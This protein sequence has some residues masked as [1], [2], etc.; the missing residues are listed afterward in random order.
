MRRNVEAGLL[1]LAVLAGFYQ[2]FHLAGTGFG[3]GFEM[4][5]IAKSLVDH[6]TYGNPFEPAIT[7]PTALVP[8]LYPL[9]LAALLK[10]FGSLL[11]MALVADSVNIFANAL[12]AALMP[13]LSEVFFEDWR[14][15]AFAGLL[16]ICSMR[17]MPQWDASCTIA[18]LVVFCLVTARTIGH[19]RTPAWQAAAAGLLAGMLSL[20]NPATAIVFLSWTA[21]LLFQRRAGLKGAARYAAVLLL[22]LSAC[23]APWVVRNYR[24]WHA[25]VLRTS[26]GITLYSSNNSCAESSLVKDA[27][28]GC[29]QATHPVAS[30]AEAGLLARLGEV[31]YDRDRAAAAW[32]W[33]RGNPARFRQLTLARI[34][35]FWFPEP[36]VPPYPAYGIWAITLLSIPGMALMARQRHA[37][38]LF[39]LAVWLVY[40][41]M[42]YLV[43]SCDRYRYPILW[44]SMLPAGYCLAALAKRKRLQ[45]PLLYSEHRALADQRL[46]AEP[47]RAGRRQLSA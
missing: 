25:F 35:E 32:A 13:R 27:A 42:Y 19:V 28:H 14:P 5:A 30:L 2:F 7:G 6:G 34:I 23:N 31:Q 24:I 16:W 39:V 44:T 17:L 37:V 47:G 43:V 1:C 22:V 18:G 41:L 36:I 12:I 21:F 3:R 38:A 11:G 26:F 4:A 33:I 20:L 40:P 10:I 15:G 46:A 9:F 45:S 29:F 8:P